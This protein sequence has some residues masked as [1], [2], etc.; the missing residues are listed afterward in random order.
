MYHDYYYFTGFSNIP[1]M[2]RRINFRKTSFM[3]KDIRTLCYN[4]F[5]FVFATRD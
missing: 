5:V 2:N 1:D 3:E 4:V